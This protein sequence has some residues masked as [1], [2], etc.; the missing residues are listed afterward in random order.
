MIKISKIS[1]KKSQRLFFT[2]FV[3]FLNISIFHSHNYDFSTSTPTYSDLSSE[4]TQLNDLSHTNI[5]C[6]I[7]SFNKSIAEDFGSS[8]LIDISVP[9]INLKAQKLFTFNSS[10]YS[11]QFNLRAPP[12]SNV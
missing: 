4:S 11:F 1:R 5:N 3:L 10:N 9:E 12:S 2:I 6:I 7:H 8:S